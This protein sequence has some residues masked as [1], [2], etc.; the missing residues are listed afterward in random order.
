M[1]RLLRNFGALVAYG[2][3]CAYAGAKA[4]LDLLALLS[5]PDDLAKVMEKLPPMLDWLFSTPWWVPS[6]FLAAYVAFGL[7]LLKPAPPDVID[8]GSFRE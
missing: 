1:V 2:V 7:W 5:A 3:F 8:G 4:L 6:L